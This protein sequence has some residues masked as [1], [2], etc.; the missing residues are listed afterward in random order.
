[1]EAHDEPPIDKPNYNPWSIEPEIFDCAYHGKVLL[2]GLERPSPPPRDVDA[3]SAFR[4]RNEI[5]SNNTE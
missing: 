2:V 3:S 4:N 1:M 5:V